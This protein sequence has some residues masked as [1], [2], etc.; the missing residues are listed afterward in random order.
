M[1]PEINTSRVEHS[2]CIK[3]RHIPNPS[4][5]SLK[6]RDQL[7]A[8][9][10]GKSLEQCNVDTE[11]ICRIDAQSNKN[12]KQRLERRVDED[13]EELVKY[14]SSIPGYLQHIKRGY[15]LQDKALNFG[16]LEWRNLEN[17]MHRQKPVVGGSDVDSPSSSCASSST[18]T[19][20]A[21]NIQNSVLSHTLEKRNR[22]Y[23]ASKPASYRNYE[24]RELS[25]CFVESK[26]GQVM[27]S[28][29][30]ES[31]ACVGRLNSESLSKFQSTSP[32]NHLKFECAASN[33]GRQREV[34]KIFLENFVPDDGVSLKI[35]SGKHE[36]AMSTNWHSTVFELGYSN[37][38]YR[39][40]ESPSL[41]YS[42]DSRKGSRSSSFRTASTTCSDVTSLERPTSSGRSRQ[43]PLR[44]LLD[45]LLKPRSSNRVRLDNESC[46]AQKSISSQ[47]SKSGSLSP[48]PKFG[49]SIQNEQTK[50][51]NS[52]SPLKVT[53]KN[54]LP[55]FTLTVGNDI[56]A[57]TK[58]TGKDDCEWIYTIYSVNEVKKRSGGWMNQK[59][60][61]CGY[62]S[63]MVGQ[64][65]VKLTNDIEFVLFSSEQSHEIHE[66]T[67]F[68]P[69]IESAAIVIKAST[70]KTE[71][72]TEGENHNVD[73]QSL[74]SVVV[75]IPSGVHSLPA[76]GK[77]SPLIERWRS[78]GSCDCGGWDVS[79][80]LTILSN[81]T[82]D[83]E[84]SVHRVELFTQVG[85]Q[86]DELMF[87]LATFK[88]DLYLVDFDA[89]INS[90]QAFAICIAILHD[91]NQ[92]EMSKIQ[93]ILHKKAS[94]STQEASAVH[95][96]YP[97]LSPVGRA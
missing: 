74:S 1:P 10:E 44:R 39:R 50:A 80:K 31:N 68:F 70:E 15:D 93:P 9:K 62:Q 66:T 25:S 67:C 18:I 96:P 52:Q 36:R 42:T 47:E 76:T 48:L 90:T 78:G 23:P 72:T 57:G 34:H 53:W 4:R 60:K 11:A 84:T 63:N 24:P 17:W 41:R 86:E 7:R 94:S 6:L 29:D 19:S 51:S 8:A 65:K 32:K 75:I 20:S 59:N 54:G 22:G 28:A 77:P 97:P 5:R 64:M 26:D 92:P 27:V 73:S 49:D 83:V 38:S 2:E 30:V 55:L 91:I 71:N 13:E 40:D 56:L 61:N 14:M 85:G 79:C 33:A 45:P 88:E 81:R 21:L 37:R 82:Q 69:D 58:R 12:G 46:H 16:V 43:S 35:Q 95:V 3:E 87:R 89:R